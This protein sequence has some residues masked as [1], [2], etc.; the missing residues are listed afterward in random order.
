MANLSAV[1]VLGL[2]LALF[3]AVCQHWKLNQFLCGC[4]FIAAGAK[5][6]CPF[7]SPLLLLLVLFQQLLTSV[8]L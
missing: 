8:T 3:D 6:R 7:P 4:I 1:L 5:M 2:W